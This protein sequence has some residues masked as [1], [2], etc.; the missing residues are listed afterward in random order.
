M[1]LALDR[2]PF[3]PESHFLFWKPGTA[4][5]YEPDGFSW[6]LDSGNYLVLNTHLQPTGKSEQVQPAIA[7]YFTDK[8]PDRFPI[9][10]QLEH[11]GA[12][13]IPPGTRDFRVSD[14]FRLPIDADV[15]AVYPHAHYLGKLLEGYATLPDGTRKW[16][17]RI[18]DWD[19]DWQAVY[20]DREPVFLPK[21]SVVSMR[22]HYDNS[23]ANPRNPN[24]PSKRVRAGNQANRERLSR[25]LASRELLYP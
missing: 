17:I 25:Q 15:L 10:I 23:A 1:D 20:R 8:P 2:N 13:D 16:L 14:D 19:L 7:L 21:N 11:D 12:L 9:L 24:Q 4:P 6:R 18:P 3:D 5:H 22:Y